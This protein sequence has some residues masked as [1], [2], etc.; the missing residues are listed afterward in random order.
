MLSGET[1]VEVDLDVD[2]FS[3]V[4]CIGVSYLNL[5]TG[6]EHPGL[7]P[8]PAK[9]TRHPH[10]ASSKRKDMYCSGCRKHMEDLA[11]VGCVRCATCRALVRTEDLRWYPL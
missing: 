9:W 6:E 3:D 10:C 11:Q 5:L 8:H 7:C 2:I 1:A 4:Q